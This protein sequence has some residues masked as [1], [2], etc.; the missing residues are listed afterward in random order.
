VAADRLR[1]SPGLLG[2]PPPPAPAAASAALGTLHTLAA[3]AIIIAGLYFA[4]DVLVPFALATL[5]TFLLAPLV[6]RLRRSGLARVPAVITVVCLSFAAIGAVG[7]AVTIQLLDLAQGLPQ[8]EE[9]IRQKIQGFQGP[10][11]GLLTRTGEMFQ[12]LRD[13]LAPAADPDAP[14]GAGRTPIP[15]EIRAPDPTSLDLLRTVAGSL[16]GPLATAGIVIVL[17]IFMLIQREDLRDR[18]FGLVGTGNLHDTT[19]ALDDAAVRI[20][21][22]LLMQFLVN[23]SYGIPVGVG[24]YFIGVPN[25]LL[26]GVLATLLRFIPYIG[27]LLAMSIPL[28]LAFA[29]D[30]GWT[31]LL[32][33][34]GLFVVLELFSNNI[35]EPWLY[36][37][38]TG[39]SPV[40]IMMAAIFW[41]SLWGPIGLLLSTP[42]TVCL[43]VFGRHFPQLQFLSTM[44]GT[45]SAL[46]PEARFYQRLLASDV[47]EAAEIAEEVRVE[48]GLVRVYDQLLLPAL[49]LLEH[50]RHRG[51][52]DDE[53][54]KFVLAHARELADDLEER[55]GVLPLPGG[56]SADRPR[57]ILLPARDEADE[58]SASMLRHLLARR[59][60]DASVVSSA[61]MLGDRLEVVRSQPVEVVCVCAVPP[62]AVTHAAYTC[63]RLR[64]HSQDVPVVVGVFSVQADAAKLRT[65]LPPE[66]ADEVV[67]S[68]EEAATR[69]HARAAGSPAAGW[70]PAPI[71]SNEHE[72]LEEL[73]RFG[74][75]DTPPEEAFDR[76]TRELARIFGAPI[77][78]MSL[79]DGERQFWKSQFGLPADLAAAGASDRESSMCGHVVGENDV[80]VVGDTRAD[81]RFAGNPFLQRC[82]IRFYAGAPLRTRSGSAVGSLCVIDT[83]PRE[84]TDR[85]RELLRM[86]ADAVMTEMELRAASRGLSEV[87]QK[88]IDENRS[89]QGELDEVT[90]DATGAGLS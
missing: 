79:V 31:M 56:L 66:L 3:S 59:G 83:K 60:I 21:R 48:G 90:R 58:I 80:L 28:V 25:P 81:P 41:T 38:S 4:R 69:I 46:P 33:T 73:A 84:I 47:E 45:E 85:E 8:Y 18:F 49:I 87:S 89:L 14:L 22:Y 78:L 42:L 63:R 55:E 51:A 70:V 1:D 27:P 35:M 5:L 68:L 34:A 75:L 61:L 64:R 16:L 53:R 54:K 52:L 19:E 20:S 86:V 36:G 62:A 44:L 10:G 23:L 71:L 11:S 67:T 7:W 2:Q 43:V 24:L 15:V 65:H 57:V 74:L 40:A 76:V 9:T 50:D 13:D 32:L 30:P 29:V 6:L 17:V 82:G 26:W 39:I 77:S 37:A 12:H 88:L 72:R